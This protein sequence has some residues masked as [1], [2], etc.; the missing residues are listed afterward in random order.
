MSFDLDVLVQSPTGQPVGACDHAVS[1]ERYIVD[2]R[3]FRTLRYV[4][5]PAINVR[6]PINGAD[7]VQMW[8]GERQVKSNDPVYGWRVVADPNRVDVATS[9]AFYKIVFNSPVRV[10]LPL[11]EVSYITRQPYCLK[12]SGLG[13]VNDLKPSQSGEFVTAVQTVQLMQKAIKWILTSKC[14]FYP[15]FTCPIKDYIGRKLG[16]QITETDV[17]TQVLNALTSLQQVQRAQATVQSLDPAEIL[18]DIVNVSAVLDNND[19]TVLRVSA[20][21]VSFQG[22]TTPFGFTLR[23]NQ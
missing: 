8:V 23:M 2:T 20:T 22:T 7:R 10:I 21:V 3:D 14:A 5:N 13:I 18:K 1:F 12:C 19:P 9:D 6:A 16:I 17:H 4:G 11:I 15:T